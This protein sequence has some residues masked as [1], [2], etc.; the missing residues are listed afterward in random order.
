MGLGLNLW[1]PRDEAQYFPDSDNLNIH[2]NIREI[3]ENYTIFTPFSK[4]LSVEG[5]WQSLCSKTIS[6]IKETILYKSAGDISYKDFVYEMV[7]EY[8]YTK[9]EFVQ[10][11]I[12]LFWF[13][14]LQFS[15]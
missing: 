11:H 7:L 3:E 10:R 6:Y 15:F 14:F 5:D 8:L 9:T 13:L 4:E 1:G 12:A 2:K